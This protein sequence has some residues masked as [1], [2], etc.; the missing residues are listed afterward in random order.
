MSRSWRKMFS[1][2]RN[3]VEISDDFPSA[4]SKQDSNQL[5]P[6]HDCIFMFAL[7]RVEKPGKP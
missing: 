7:G 4:E 6:A 1:K 2:Q 3:T 5:N